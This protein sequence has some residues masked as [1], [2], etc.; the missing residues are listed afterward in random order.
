MNVDLFTSTGSKKGSLELPALLFEAPVNQ[1]LMHQALVMQQSNRRN[2]VAHA[3]N[4]SEVHGSSKKLFQQKG[5]GRARR[6]N[7]RSPLLRGGG[8]AHGPRSNANFIKEMPRAMRVAALKS[9]LSM[10]ASE[11]GIVGLEHCPQEAKT[12]STFALLKKLPVELG[13][14]ILFVIPAKEQAFERA[15]RNIPRVTTVRA[16]YLNI[17]DVLLAHKIIITADA[18]KLAESVF[19]RKKVRT[20][21][22]EGIEVNEGTSES[23]QS[24]PPLQSSKKKVAKKKPSTKKA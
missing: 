19:G 17:E 13:R 7:V 16:D 22:K 9:A 3:K 10:Q 4:R 21:K 20:A 1:G 2:T 15:A 12:K 24:L 18:V 11:G 14:R 6:G 5:T 8:K 23:L